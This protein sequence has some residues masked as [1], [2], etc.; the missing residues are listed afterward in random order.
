MKRFVFGASLLFSVVTLLALAGSSATAAHESG[1]FKARLNGFNEVPSVSTTGHGRFRAEINETAQT[2]EYTLT[3]SELE[4]PA[5][6]AHV[7]FAKRRVA[8]GVIAFLC[9]GGDKPDCPAH[10]GTVTGTIDAADVVGPEEQGIEPGSFGELVHA[11]R[12]RATYVNVHSTRFPA[13]EIRGQIHRG[14]R[15]R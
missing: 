3:Y 10:G 13:G 4:N 11:M 2:I 15:K 8:G 9:G 5:T 6:A 12:A 1:V 7:H 14:D